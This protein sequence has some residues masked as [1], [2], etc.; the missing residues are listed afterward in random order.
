[1]EMNSRDLERQAKKK[2]LAP[3]PSFT[4][5]DLVVGWRLCTYELL[6][7][8]STRSSIY[9]FGAGDPTFGIEFWYQIDKF[10]WL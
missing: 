5:E 7:I 8:L 2:T 3:P 10:A 6:Q 9:S 1:M 4:G